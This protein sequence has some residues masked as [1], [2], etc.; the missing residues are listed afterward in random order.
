ML[1][2]RA[3]CSLHSVS[4][5]KDG[6]FF[7]LWARSLISEPSRIRRS[8]RLFRSL[9][10]KEA[11]H[12]RAVMLGNHVHHR[13]WKSVLG[14]K[15]QPVRH[16]RGDDSSTGLRTQTVMRADILSRVLNEEVW[17]LKL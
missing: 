1:A 13:S 12:P 14:P 8:G 2:H 4:Q 10:V 6:C 11:H 7:G 17:T 15:R 5:H 3:G 16:V 9:L